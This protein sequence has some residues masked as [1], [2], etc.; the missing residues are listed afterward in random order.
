MSD[1]P[2][3]A[4]PK[5]AFGAFAGPGLIALVLLGLMARVSAPGAAALLLTLVAMAFA[6]VVLVRLAVPSE[7]SN[8]CLLVFG[9]ILG[10]LLGRIGLTVTGLIPAAHTQGLLIVAA[11]SLGLGAWLKRGRILSGPGIEEDRA[12]LPWLAAV[13]GV[14]L[15]LM[16]PPLLAVGRLTERG[17]AFVAHFNGDFF[18]H[19][20]IAAELTRGLPP[21]NPLFAGEPLHYYWAYHL[22]PAA[23]AGLTGMPV[24]EAVILT[25]VPTVAL[26][27]AALA[28]V[29]RLDIPDRRARFF[30]I[31]LALFAYSYIGLLYVA[32]VLSPALL[33][34]LPR[35]FTP[36]TGYTFLSHSWYRDFLY[37]PHAVTALTLLLLVVYL[38]RV[39]RNSAL[40]RTFIGLALGVSVATDAFIGVIGLCWYGAACLWRL[41]QGRGAL[42]LHALPLAVAAALLGGAM[43]LGIL[44]TSGGAVRL[45]VHP[46]A[47]FGPLYLLVELGPL[48]VFGVIGLGLAMASR[49]VSSS[50]AMLLLAGPSLLLAFLLMVP[51]EPNQALRKGM[52]VLQFPLVVFAA[53]AFAAYTVRPRLPWLSAASA[54]VLL[55]GLVTLGTDVFQYVDLL[56]RKPQPTTY[57]RPEEMQVL[58]WTRT[59]TPR[60]AVFQSLSEVRPGRSFRDTSGSLISTFGE[61]RT[62]SGDYRGA[63]LFQ[64]SETAIERRRQRL[65]DLFTAADARVIREILEELRPDYLYVDEKQPGPVDVIRQ[66]EASG[67]LHEVYRVAGISVVR[68]K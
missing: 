63:E 52:K 19:T 14:V 34:M 30:G 33:R 18:H 37:E 38:D 8:L 55:S 7:E 43:V 22:W 58:D 57:V 56:G 1:R 5:G 42:L 28:L 54:V 51:L 65:E 48:F 62:L 59:H 9:S 39:S 41:W 35:Y 11:L 29:V 40:A 53:N 21:Q 20:A 50:G 25:V 15:L 36:D 67:F 45:A 2:M 47:K 4:W 13:T 6:G 24:R 68:V 31:G 23:V 10:L 12:D 26:F 32:N 61:R 46:I 16:T 60:D 66:L 64:V 49:Q 27:I 3:S 17:Y 44:P